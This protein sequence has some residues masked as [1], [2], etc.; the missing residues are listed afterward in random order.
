MTRRASVDPASSRRAAQ[1]E[2]RQRLVSYLGDLPTP[3]GLPSARLVRRDEEDGRAIEVLE[4]DL[5]GIEPVPAV[6]VRPLST[7]GPVPVVIYSHASGDPAKTEL[8]RGHPYLQSPPYA[9]EL[10]KLGFASICIDMWSY[11]E[12]RGKTQDDLFKEMLW[13]GQTLWGMMVY[14]TLRLIDFVV[15]REDVD[16]SRIGAVG[17]S[18]GSTMSWW[19]AALD[20]RVKVCV[21]LCCL[22]DFDALIEA[23][24]LSGHG[25]YYFVPG[26]LKEF[27]SAEIN[28]LIAP[29]PHLS[30]AG[31][32]DRLTPPT[33]L[34]RIDASL[35]S[36]YGSWGASDAWRLLRYNTGHFETAAMRAEIL[37]FLEKHL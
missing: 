23:N 22:T 7:D 34:D 17:L 36:E 32:F 18:L 4:L 1:A 11:G 10:A 12:R 15:G 9:V 26:L 28:G 2:R 31:N 21:D 8:L 37:R 24:A 25:T 27:S 30:V 14:D 16:A 19:I 6:F 29:R 5:N 33:G 35:K 3:D 20:V 13:R